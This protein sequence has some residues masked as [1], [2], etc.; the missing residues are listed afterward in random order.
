MMIVDKPNGG[1]FLCIYAEPVKK[2]CRVARFKS[3]RDA[4]VAG[5]KRLEGGKRW[6]CPNCE[7][8]K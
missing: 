3:Y 4:M 7:E 2:T 6:V 8:R 1:E 5:W